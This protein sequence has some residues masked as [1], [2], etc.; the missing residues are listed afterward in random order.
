MEQQNHI[1]AYK[2]DSFIRFIPQ[3]LQLSREIF[4]VHQKVVVIIRW[5][6]D[7]IRNDRLNNKYL[8]STPLKTVQSLC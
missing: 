2:V 3:S 8:N 7:R 4:H 1:F 5:N 6:R